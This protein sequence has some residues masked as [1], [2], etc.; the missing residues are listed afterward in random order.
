MQTASE[1]DMAI[2]IKSLQG[3]LALLTTAHSNGSPS[4][5]E[6]DAADHIRVALRALTDA[7]QALQGS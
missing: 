2:Q 3:R 7:R 5:K 6:K 4:V 1:R